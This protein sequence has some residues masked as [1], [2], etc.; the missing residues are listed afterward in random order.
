V[1]TKNNCYIQKSVL[2]SHSVNGLK[3]LYI[4]QLTVHCVEESSI[5]NV[6]VYITELHEPKSRSRFGSRD[7]FWDWTWF[8]GHQ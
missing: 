2:L 7:N 1:N 4:H 8:N 6:N 3:K 5:K